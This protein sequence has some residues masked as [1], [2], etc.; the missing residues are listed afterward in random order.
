M[1]R[2]GA[3]DWWNDNGLRLSASLAPLILLSVGLLGVVLERQQVASQ[4][5]A[6]LEGFIGL[7][8]RELVDSMLM[9]TS[10]EGGT[11]ATVVGLQATM[12]LISAVS[13]TAASAAHWGAIPSGALCT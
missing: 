1:T 3:P 9:T 2:R 12:P 7:A 4:L 5:A 13:P 8:G 10:P 11:C 6:R